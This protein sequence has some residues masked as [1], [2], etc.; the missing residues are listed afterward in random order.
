M[1]TLAVALRSAA[2]VP[3]GLHANY[4]QPAET[5]PHESRAARWSYRSATS[6]SVA[7]S[8]SADPHRFLPSRSSHR[9]KTEGITHDLPCFA[10][11][12]RRHK[13]WQPIRRR[14]GRTKRALSASYRRTRQQCTGPRRSGHRELSADAP[15]W[16]NAG[17]PGASPMARENAPSRQPAG[18]RLHRRARGMPAFTSPAHRADH[19]DPDAR[20]SV[21]TGSS[22]V[23]YRVDGG[24]ARRFLGRDLRRILVT[25]V[26]VTHTSWRRWGGLGNVCSSHR[27]MA[28]IAAASSTVRRSKTAKR[29]GSSAAN[30]S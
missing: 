17:Q 5:W 9:S 22:C 23:R 8:A 26:L 28:S 7:V 15:A 6:P 4:R 25:R 14:P 2:P 11:P 29:S 16:V 30:R 27:S 21:G 13:E 18:D 1:T 20:W 3:L 10:S 19:E 24:P 12:R